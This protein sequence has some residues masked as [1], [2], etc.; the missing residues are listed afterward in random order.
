MGGTLRGVPKAIC[1][2]VTLWMLL[3]YNSSTISTL[4]FFTTVIC[5]LHYY[6]YSAMNTLKTSITLSLQLTQKTKLPHADFVGGLI[7]FF[8]FVTI[9][10]QSALGNGSP[11]VIVFVSSE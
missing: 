6:R 10:E 11:V 3:I 7:F 9:F 5:C 1:M 4:Q 8:I 2:K